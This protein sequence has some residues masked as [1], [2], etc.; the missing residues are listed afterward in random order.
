MPTNSLVQI[1]IGAAV[2]KRAAALLGGLG[3]TVS[4]AVRIP[5]TGTPMKA[6]FPLS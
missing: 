4:A 5:L 6:R 1:L 2:K 3:I